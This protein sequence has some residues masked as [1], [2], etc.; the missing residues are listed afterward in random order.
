MQTPQNQSCRRRLAYDRA[1]FVGMPTQSKMD[2]LMEINVYF[3]LW[4]YGREICTAV[5]LACHRIRKYI[6]S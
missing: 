3:C 5:L 6:D 2:I 4:I 1:E